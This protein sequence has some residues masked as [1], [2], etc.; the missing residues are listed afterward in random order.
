M[1]KAAKSK[2]YFNGKIPRFTQKE[3]DKIADAKP[4][5]LLLKAMRYVRDS[6]KSQR[7]A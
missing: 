4:S 7:S 1:S 2:S 5:A 3:L 6:E